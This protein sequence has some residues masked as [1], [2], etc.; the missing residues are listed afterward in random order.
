MSAIRIN[1]I[2]NNIKISIRNFL[3]PLSFPTSSN[4]STVMLGTWGGAILC[5]QGDASNGCATNGGTLI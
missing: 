3:N 5:I 2:D 4:G 1:N